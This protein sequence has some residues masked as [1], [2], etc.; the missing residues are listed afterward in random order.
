MTRL[1]LFSP[2]ARRRLL[3]SSL[4][5]LAL[6][7][8][9]A[10]QGVSPDADAQALARQ[11]AAP[12]AAQPAELPEILVVGA[13]RVPTPKGDLGTSVSVVTSEEIE[14]R[15]QRLLP[16][17]LRDLPGLN[18][19]Q[20]GGPGGQTSVFIRG[21]NSNHTKVLIDGMDVSDPST[22]NGSFDFA[23]VLNFDV[24]QIEVLRGPQS[25]IYGSDA[26]GGVV[27]IITDPGEGPMKA[28]VTAEAGS[29]GLFNQFGRVSGS[30]D[31]I[32]YFLGY[33]HFYSNDVEVTPQNLVPPGRGINPNIYDNSTFSVRLG[34]KLTEIFD[35]GLVGRYTNATLWSTSDDFVGPQSMLTGSFTNQN[36]SRVFVHASLLDGRFDNTVGV[37]YVDYAR[38]VMDPNFDPI[39]RNL[40]S[41]SRVKVDYLGRFNV[42]EGQTLIF[43]AERESNRVSNSSPLWAA[44]GD[45]AGYVTLQ[46]DFGGRLFNAASVRY[47]ANDQF[48]GRATFRV[49]PALLF[50]ETGTKLKASVGTGFKAPSLDQ[51]YNN[52]PAFNFYGNPDLGPETSV[53]W[54]A[55]VEQ[56]LLPGR[57]SF[58]ATYF[59]NDIKNLIDFNSTF[60]SYVNVGQARTQ[61]LESFM[62]LSPFDGFSVVANYTYTVAI[63][64][65]DDLFLLRRPRDKV[66]LTATLQAT[67]R[68]LL[69]ANLL[70]VGPWRD[71]NRSGSE[72]YILT[73]GYTLLNFTGAYDFGHGLTAFGRIENALNL[74]YQNPLG[75]QAPG[76]GV[77]GGVRF[78]FGQNGLL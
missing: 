39:S 63:N 73:P 15:Q 16:D 41:G 69:T 13:T 54:D 12:A 48:G 49:A 78:A 17:S 37:S 31:R 43:G 4:S 30:T 62:S 38:N 3:L 21:T 67:E 24:S 29:F 23:H 56:T 64:E 76:L 33:G 47:D 46:S 77:F 74:R 26:I 34:A 6:G 11:D 75:F 27:N 5:L 28:K 9:A 70:Y 32:S 35:V 8:A 55:G 14:A 1:S 53:G 18:V 72:S 58:G 10:A 65:D 52:Y 51:L 44:N 59:N 25:G 61:G 60:T 68:L 42:I 50:P 20:T 40:Y 66:S 45:T 71:V 2:A 7:S 36:F 22:P 57:I 19:A